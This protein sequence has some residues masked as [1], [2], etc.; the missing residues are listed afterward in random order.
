MA[1][2]WWGK[3]AAL[4]LTYEGAT[5]NQA[6]I[7]LPALERA[8][9]TATFYADPVALLE[10][11]IVWQ[12]AAAL[13]HEIGNGS[14]LESDPLLPTWPHELIRQEVEAGRV[15]IEEAVPLQDTHSFAYPIG[16]AWGAD[17][18]YRSI[19]DG[20]YDVA[21]SGEDGWNERN[22][23]DPQFLRAVDFREWSFPEMLSVLDAHRTRGTWLVVV[24]GEVGVGDRAIDRAD[25]DRLLKTV[26]EQSSEWAIAP[27]VR[28]AQAVVTRT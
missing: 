10:R 27:V 24:I 11:P 2:G 22:D 18:G 8:E 15:L 23:F 14:L 1:D 7:V 4:S 26:Q 12:Q 25:H 9:L 19:V 20:L 3:R 28:L 13:G 6:E 16:H 17:G 5:R 21:R